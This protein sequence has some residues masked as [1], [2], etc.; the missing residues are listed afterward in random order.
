MITR[1]NSRIFRINKIQI[2]SPLLSFLWFLIKNAKLGLKM[3]VLK[4]I[5]IY[6]NYSRSFEQTDRRWYGILISNNNKVS[7]ILN[8]KWYFYAF[9]MFGIKKNIFL[10]NAHGNASLLVPIY[11]CWCFRFRVR[12]LNVWN[13]FFPCFHK[14]SPISTFPMT[15]SYPTEITIVKI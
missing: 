15:P 5:G 14:K 12:R 1:V 6:P 11:V 4:F 3:K 7:K 13:L 10:M 9:E 8:G 2:N